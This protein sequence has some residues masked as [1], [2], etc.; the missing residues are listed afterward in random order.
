M[1]HCKAVR[2]G[3]PN[4]FIV[5]DMPFGSYEESPEIALRNAMRFVKEVNADCCVQVVWFVTDERSRRV[6]TQ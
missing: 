5:G 6:S 4:R 1:Y 2:R 3:A